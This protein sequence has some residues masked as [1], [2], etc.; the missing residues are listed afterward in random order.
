[1][2][3]IN[4]LSARQVETL[5]SL[6]R[7]SDGGNLYLVITDAGTRQWIFRYRWQG[8]EKEIGLGSAA[9]G[10][11][12]LAGARKVAQ[13]ARDALGEGKDP[14]VLKSQAKQATVLRRTFG[15]VADEYLK[16]ME[17]GWKNNK[18]SKQWRYSLME[19]AAPLSK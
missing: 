10:R 9:P 13:A 15:Q 7:Y 18:H 11:V 3:T 4:K 14:Q 1:M 6:G 16:V 5:K 12:S 19:L 8:R 2:R 17:K